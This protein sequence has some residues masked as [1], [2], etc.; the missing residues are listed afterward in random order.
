MSKFHDFILELEDHE[1]LAIKKFR[2]DELNQEQTELLDSLIKDR[3][4]STSDFETLVTTKRKNAGSIIACPR[5]MS[6]LHFTDIEEKFPDFQ[7]IM[8]AFKYFSLNANYTCKVC[9]L[10]YKKRIPLSFILRK[11]RDY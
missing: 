4:I 9:A 8:N 1:L 10:N 11:L 3:A 2:I 7:S 6:N 5:C